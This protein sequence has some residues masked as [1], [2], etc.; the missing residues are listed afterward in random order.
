MINFKLS[1]KGIKDWDK[2]LS[3]IDSYLRNLGFRKYDQKHK[4]E[5]F[6]YWENY[7]GYSIGI[8]VYDFRKY[9]AVPHK[10][11]SLQFECMINDIDCRIDLT[12]SKSIELPEFEAMSK[13]FYNAMK[14]YN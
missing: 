3:D 1:Q 13:D 12:V 9:E 10:I 11:V 2:Y 7:D 6:A 5:D 4:G 8:L 14:R